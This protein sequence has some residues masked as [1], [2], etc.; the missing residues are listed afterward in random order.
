[1]FGLDVRLCCECLCI[2]GACF[3]FADV[4]GDWRFE[5]DVL[6]CCGRVCQVGVCICFVVY[7]DGWCMK[8]MS[9]YVVIG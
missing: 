3:C 8:L 5:F 6:L 9:G 1:M 2:V 7:V 4:V